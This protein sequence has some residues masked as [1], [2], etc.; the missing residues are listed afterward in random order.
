MS[1]FLTD[2]GSTQIANAGIDLLN[3]TIKIMLIDSGASPAKTNNFV[4]ALSANE[5]AVSGYTGGFGG[6]GRKTLATWSALAAGVTIRYALIIKEITNDAASP[7]IAVID[8]TSV[9]TNG[10]DI[11]LH[12]GSNGCF[13]LQC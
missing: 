4:S 3:N 7:I 10:S 13:Y 1:S 5:V 12:W 2:K 6:S 8:L 11:T 9:V